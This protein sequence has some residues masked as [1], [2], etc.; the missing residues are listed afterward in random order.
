MPR[1]RMSA[2]EM[3]ALLEWWSREWPSLRHSLR[4]QLAKRG[5][6]DEEVLQEAACL[7]WE[8]IRAGQP[9]ALAIWKAAADAARGRTFVRKADHERLQC[10]REPSWCGRNGDRWWETMTVGRFHLGRASRTD[11]AVSCSE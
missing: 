4:S 7:L 6:F 1:T 5:R 2:A 10:L 11:G 8:H 3:N 9:V